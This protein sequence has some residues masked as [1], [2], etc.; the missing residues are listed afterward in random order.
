MLGGARREPMGRSLW[1]GRSRGD[2]GTDLLG[3]C[4]AAGCSA[5]IVRRIA[6]SAYCEMVRAIREA[7]QPQAHSNGTF[8]PRTWSC[9]LPVGRQSQHTGRCG[10][11]DML[12]LHNQ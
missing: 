2:A 10:C 8:E 11:L 3:R 6:P 12:V 4:A 9:D 7:W 1:E 5:R